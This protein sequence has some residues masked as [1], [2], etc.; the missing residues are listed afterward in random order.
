MG[1]QQESQEAFEAERARFE[2]VLLVRQMTAD[3]NL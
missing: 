1:G 2:F 3:G